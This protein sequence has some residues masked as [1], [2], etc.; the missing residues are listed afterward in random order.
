MN[1]W[2][3]LRYKIYFDYNTQINKVA[4]ADGPNTFNL[5]FDARYY[6]SIFQNFI[7]AGRAAGDFS[8]GNQKYCIT[9][10][11]WT[12][13]YLWGLISNQMVLTDTL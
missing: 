2:N 11:V 8:W 13:G 12:A 3:G 9:W 4:A 7:W 10:V 5:G 6:Y 1:I